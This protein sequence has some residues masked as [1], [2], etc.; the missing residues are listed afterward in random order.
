MDG[1]GC[2][3]QSLGPKAFHS[4]NGEQPADIAHSAQRRLVLPRVLRKPLRM[5][6]RIGD[7][8]FSV[9]RF[10][11]ISVGLIVAL[12]SGYLGWTSSNPVRFANVTSSAGFV[13]KHINMS[14]A[15]H[16]QLSDIRKQLGGS[17]NIPLMDLSAR[18]ARA[19]ITEISWVKESKVLKIY[20]DT[21][22]IDIVEHVPFAIWQIEGEVKLISN[23]GTVLSD[24][25]ELSEYPEYTRLPYIVGHGA[26]VAAQDFFKIIGDYPSLSAL[27]IAYVR[28]ADRR[29]D[30]TMMG[31]IKVMLPENGAADALDAL[32]KLQGEQDILARD[33]E[34]VDMRLPDRF[35][36]RLSQQ[37]ADE[38]KLAHNEQLQTMKKALHKARYGGGKI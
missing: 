5:M 27:S 38:R 11:W 24:L 21:L 14:G 22:A 33:L 34:V 19:A 30:L 3:L 16:V 35:T 18:D 32:Y 26:N 15:T 23:D 20:P 29:W 28:V 13:V 9:P 12:I 8:G 7:E 4:K 2:N 1:G 31:G 36:I 10:L 25:A 6:S 17:L 37:S